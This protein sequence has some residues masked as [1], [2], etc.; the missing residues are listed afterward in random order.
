MEVKIKIDKRNKQAKAF[1]EYLKSLPFVELEEIRY[2]K[3]T[4]R[5]IQDANSGDTTEISLDEFRKVLYT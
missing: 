5:A 4:E 1:Y 3:T 2:N